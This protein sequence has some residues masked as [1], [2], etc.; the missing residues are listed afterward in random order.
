L[1]QTSEKA[2]PSKTLKINEAYRPV[3]YFRH[4]AIHLAASLASYPVPI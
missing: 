3:W 1:W 4:K 2:Y